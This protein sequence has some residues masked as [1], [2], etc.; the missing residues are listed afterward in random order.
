MSLTSTG[1]LET[2]WWFLLRGWSKV[3]SLHNLLWL[4]AHLAAA[5]HH[6]KA[7]YGSLLDLPE[8]L[9]CHHKSNEQR[10]TREVKGIPLNFTTQLI[11]GMPLDDQTGWRTHFPSP[12]R[13]ISLPHNTGEVQWKPEEIVYFWR[14]TP[15]A[16]TKFEDSCHVK[17]NNNTLQ[18]WYGS[19]GNVYLMDCDIT[20]HFRSI[21]PVTPS[22]QGQYIF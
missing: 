2:L 18:L 10:W 16:T 5:H 3:S 17:Q 8:K 14:S 15:S 6:H 1:Y 9:F 4:L 13:T 21:I 22:N 20:T 12:D 7:T 11:P 19:T